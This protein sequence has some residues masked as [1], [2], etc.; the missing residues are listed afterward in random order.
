[1]I[2][3]TSAV[4]C[5]SSDNSRIG[6]SASTGI[7]VSPSRCLVFGSLRCPVPQL[8]GAALDATAALEQ[9]GHVHPDEREATAPQL[10]RQPGG[11]LRQDDVPPVG[12][13]V[14]P[15]H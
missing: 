10:A 11:G 8:E 15:E 13:Q 9:F 7:V 6:V 14:E 2:R 12:D 3:A 1:V 4:S 5:A